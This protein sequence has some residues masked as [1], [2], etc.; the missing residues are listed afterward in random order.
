MVIWSVHQNPSD[1]CCIFCVTVSTLDAVGGHL[2]FIL[3][4]HLVTYPS[5]VRP[6]GFEGKISDI[7][8][9]SRITERAVAGHLTVISGAAACFKGTARIDD[10]VNFAGRQPKRRYLPLFGENE[11]SSMLKL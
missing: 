3:R 10:G 11:I 9:G 1:R 6:I 5:D 8:T 4:F 7:R 2:R